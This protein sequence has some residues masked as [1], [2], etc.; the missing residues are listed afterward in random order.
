MP[1]PM[2]VAP[3]PS[4]K[5]AAKKAAPKAE[6]KERPAR[7]KAAAPKAEPAPAPVERPKRAA[8]AA[9]GTGPGEAKCAT[10]TAPIKAVKPSKKPVSPKKPTSPKR[11][12]APKEVKVAASTTPVARRTRSGRSILAQAVSAVVEVLS[13]GAEA[14]KRFVEKNFEKRAAPAAEGRTRRS[15]RLAQ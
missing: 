13:P 11:R 8:R 2:S 12:A 6:P 14:A 4:P 15:S 10:N 1:T 3:V 9:A 5:V 7:T